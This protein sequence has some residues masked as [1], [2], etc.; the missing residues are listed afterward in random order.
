MAAYENLRLDNQL[1]FA[2][3]SATHA[4]TRAY[5]SQLGELGLTYPQYL[6]LLALWD[7]PSAAGGQ[8]VKALA[9]RLALDSATLTPLLKRMAAAGLVT[10]ERDSAD[11]RVMLIRATPAAQALKRRLAHTQNQVVCRSGLSPAEF[12]ALR[13][14]LHRLTETMAAGQERDPE[15]TP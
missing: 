11:E 3:Y 8:S 13:D 6:V 12:S 15:S 10:R 2:L 1:C 5:R 7:H 4:V 14:T 9:Q